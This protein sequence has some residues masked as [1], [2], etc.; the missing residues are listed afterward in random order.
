MPPVLLLDLANIDLNHVIYGV[1][2]IEKVNPHRYEMRL[3]DGIVHL[4]A[5]AGTAVG[6]KEITEKAFWVRGHIPSRPLMPGVLM[7]EAAAQLASFTAI[8]ITREER[9]IGFGGIE[10]VKFRGQ[11]IPTCRLYILG[12]FTE[13][14]PRRFKFAAQGLVDGQLVFHATVIGMPI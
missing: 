10:D 2:D 8:K 7:V 14:R 9:F 13:R 12:K 4:D 1:E 3:L 11:V 6:F 5:D